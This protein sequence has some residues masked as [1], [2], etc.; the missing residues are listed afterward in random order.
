VFLIAEQDFG[1]TALKTNASLVTQH[2]EIAS[3]EA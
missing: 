2:V 3:L 1:M